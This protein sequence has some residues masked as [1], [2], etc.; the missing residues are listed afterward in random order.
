MLATM[1]I[2]IAL[3]LMV[4]GL[5][6]SHAA[7][8]SCTW[9][10]DDRDD[11]VG[12]SRTQTPQKALQAIRLVRT[13]E[14]YRL[15]HVYDVVSLSPLPFG[16][17]FELNVTPFTFEGDSQAFNT[18]L[19]QAHI[20]QLGTQ[21]DALG[22]AG[23]DFGFY[24]CVDELGPNEFGELNKLGVE[25]VRPFVTRAVLLDFL[26]HSSVPK[27]VANGQSL[28]RDSYVITRADVEEVMRS[29]GI[30]AIGEGDVVLFYTGWDSLY[31]RDNVRH[32]NSPGP[33]IEVARW[34]AE[35]RIA[36]VGTDTQHGEAAIEGR[37]TELV[38]NP[39][40]LGRELGFVFNAVHFILITQ[41]GIHLM[42]W[43]RLGELAEALLKDHRPIQ[44][45]ARPLVGRRPTPY[46]FLFVYSP[47]PVKGLAG[48]PASPLA[49]R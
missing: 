5:G 4:V 38:Q 24:N 27:V 45:T 14:T 9:F 36:M 20:G 29:E 16:R 21:F 22:H 13:G 39:D 23:H 43:M 31:G 40:V 49:I 37:S 48:S 47:L 33:G 28:V 3:L 17:I 30:S 32:F 46:E 8:R 1:K 15:G 18:G 12:A 7:N 26:N 25:H 11:Q 2:G 34:L 44:P 6:S 35:K 41:H 10:Q 42:E 19:L